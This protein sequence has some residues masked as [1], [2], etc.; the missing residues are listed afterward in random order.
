MQERAAQLKNS[1]DAAEVLA[2]RYALKKN[3]VE[4][5][6]N[7]TEWATT[8][9]LDQEVLEKTVRSLL[10]LGLISNEEA[11]DWSDKLIG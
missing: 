9:T 4:E 3:E 7:Q 2:W 10:D 11:T 8:T 1:T 6:L 5:W